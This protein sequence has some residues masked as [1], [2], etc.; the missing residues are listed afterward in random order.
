MN[1]EVIRDAV[2]KIVKLKLKMLGEPDREKRR[3]LK[4]KINRIYKSL[5]S[6]RATTG[7]KSSY[8][9]GQAGGAGAG[10]D[11]LRFHQDELDYENC[12]SVSGRH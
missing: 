10:S 8:K 5:I 12:G 1:P 2:K 4:K 3:K 9:A 6:P 11:A 7:L